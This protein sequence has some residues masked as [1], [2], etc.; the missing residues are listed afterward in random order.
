MKG[1]AALVSVSLAALFLSGCG[2]V[3]YSRKK[4]AAEPPPQK[5]LKSYPPVASASPNAFSTD[6]L[7]SA[8][9]PVQSAFQQEWP[10]AMVTNVVTRATGAGPFVYDIS[11]ID[12]GRPGVVTYAGDGSQFAGR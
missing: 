11:F 1:A 12:D 5:P 8:P 6:K 9:A 2:W 7:E 10:G 4:L 3:G